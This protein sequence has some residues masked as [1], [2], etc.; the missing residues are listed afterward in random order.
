MTAYHPVLGSLCWVT[1][2]NGHVF[3]LLITKE[4]LGEITE[5]K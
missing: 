5:N 1:C 4:V 2:C 3:E